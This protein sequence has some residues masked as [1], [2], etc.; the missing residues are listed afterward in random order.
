MAKTI[1]ATRF[2]GET[3][4]YRE[5]RNRLLEEEIDLRRKIEAVAARRRALPLGG[6]VTKDYVFD[7]SSPDGGKPHTIHFRE[8]F[9]PGKDTLDA[10]ASL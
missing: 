1:H 5:A 8:L 3:E 9:S 10:L 2:P 6:E 7:A 4:Q